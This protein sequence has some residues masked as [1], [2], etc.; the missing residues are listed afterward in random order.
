M[1]DAVQSFSSVFDNPDITI[2]Q[3]EKLPTQGLLVLEFGS[4]RNGQYRY[5][6]VVSE[7]QLQ[8]KEN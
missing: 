4:S 2:T 7:Q 3:M 8:T 1:G 5:V 6:E